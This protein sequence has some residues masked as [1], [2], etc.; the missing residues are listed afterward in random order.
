MTR[1]DARR[2]AQRLGYEFEIDGPTDEELDAIR[3]AY[4]GHT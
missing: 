1:S 2:L 4:S 3:R